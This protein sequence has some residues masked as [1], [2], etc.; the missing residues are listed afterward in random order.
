V[1]KNLKIKLM[2]KILFI[3]IT[4]SVFG[5]KR[6]FEGVEISGS[7]NNSKAEKVL[8]EQLSINQIIPLDSTS[9]DADGNFEMDAKISEKGFYRLSLN[10]N[11]YIILILDSNDVVKVSGDAENIAETY[12]IESPGDSKLLWELNNYLKKNYRMRDSLQQV[13]Q[14]YMYHPDRDS[15]GRVLEN[16]YNQSVENLSTFVKSFIDNNPQSFATLAAIEQ[17]NPDSDFEYFKKVAANL[18]EKYPESAYVKGLQN[19]VTEMSRTAIGSVAPEL[20]LRNPDGQTVKLSDLR[21][22]VVLIDF[23]ASWCKPCRMENPNVVRMYNQYKSKGFEIFGVSLDK[24]K[25]AW[26]NA[27]KE[28]NL[29]WFHASDLQMWSSPVVRLYGFTGIPYTVLVDEEGK[30]IAKNL[31]GEQLERKLEEVLQ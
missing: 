23:W 18:N 29:T 9:I 1:N 24:E 14:E 22:K 3:L 13:F 30:I 31:R 20:E 7:F 17:L 6:Q 2:K 15:V 21:G 19:R 26:I 12:T 25:E 16:Q 8:L 4:I 27:I 10:P 28:D 5:C 11:N